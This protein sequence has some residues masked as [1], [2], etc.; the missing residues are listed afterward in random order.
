MDQIRTLVWLKTRLT[1]ALYRKR[2]GVLVS[3]LITLPISLTFSLGLFFGALVGFWTLPLEHSRQLLNGGLTA[4]YVMWLFG[5]M[6]GVSLNEGYDISKLMQFPVN[7]RRIFVANILGS[8][9]DPPVLLVLIPLT[10][11]PIALG[12]NAVMQALMAGVV[13][14]F[15]FHTVALSQALVT[16][17]WGLLKSRRVADFWKVFAALA[18]T[19]FW[20]AYQIAFRQM[21]RFAPSLLMARPSRFTQYLPSGLAADAIAA[22]SRGATTEFVWRAAVLGAIC[23]V[24]VALAGSLVQRVSA[25]DLVL[26]RVEQKQPERVRRARKPWRVPAWLPASA[27]VMVQNELRIFTRDPRA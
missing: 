26:D 21:D 18:G 3:L 13:L 14:L 7:G 12:A 23:V 4:I 16:L 22:I 9:I 5:P 17:L 25:G 20:A 2:K 6:L 10:A 15:L 1:L 19:V 8:A 24:T 27:A 11:I